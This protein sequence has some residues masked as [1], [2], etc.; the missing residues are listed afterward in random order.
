ME[1]RVE[2]TNSLDHFRR[3]DD[4][5]RLNNEKGQC[6]QERSRKWPVKRTYWLK[7]HEVLW[8]NQIQ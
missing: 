5:S 3:V 4:S 2:E 1:C 6:V 7:R 8:F